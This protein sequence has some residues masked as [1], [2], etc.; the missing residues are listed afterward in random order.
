MS[1]INSILTIAKTDNKNIDLIEILTSN[2]DVA[3]FRVDNDGH[4]ALGINKFNT[5][6]SDIQANLHITPKDIHIPSVLVESGQNYFVINNDGNVGIG[7]SNPS[8]LLHV[9]GD[10][11]I[12]GDLIIAGK[13]QIIDT[14]IQTTEQ[15]EITNDGTGTTLIVNQNGTGP[16]AEF[17]YKSN[18]ALYVADGGFVGINTIN[19]TTHLEIDGVITANSGIMDIIESKASQD[20]TIKTNSLERVTIDHSTGYLGINTTT[21]TTHLD[22]NGTIT[23]HN[24]I[25]NHI[26]TITNTNFTV[27]TT[28]T[29]RLTIEAAGFVGINTTSPTTQLEVDGV[30]TANAGIMDIIESKTSQDFIIKTNNTARITVDNS[31]G[32]V[33]VNTTDPTTH[34]DVNGTITS[35]NAIMNHIGTITNTN[36]TVKTTNT[37]RL[38]IEADGF[39]GINTITPTTQLEVDGVITANSGIM[40]V[41]ESK[42][43]QDFT[44]KTNNAARITVDNSSGYVGVNTTDP[45]THFDVNGTITSHNA[46]MNHIGT[47][48]NTDFTIKTT[49]LPRVTIEADGYVGINTTAP[50]TQLEVDGVIT[51]N[52]GIMDI[53]ESKT[54][55][56]FTIKTDNTARITVDNA[57]GYVG[58]NTT[59]PTT[60][61]DVNGTLTSHNAIM[62]HIGTITNTDFTIKTTDLPRITVEADGFVGINTTAPTTQLE[63]DGVITANSGIMDIIESKTS[64]DFTIKTDNTAR[65]TVDNSSGYVGINTTD[66]TTHLDVNGTITSHNAIMDHIGTITNTNFTVKTTNTPRLTIEADG[67]VGINTTAPTTQLEVDGV[68][69]ANSGIMDVIESKTS[70]DFTIKTNNTARITVDNSSGY[71]GVNT[72]NPT[73]HL[74]VNGTLTSHNAIMNH[75]GTITNTDFTIKT[76]DLPRVTIEADGYVGIN[77]ITPTTQLEVDGVLTA[78]SGIMDMIESKTSQDFTIKTNNN[79]RITVDNADGYVGI[80]TTNPNTHLDVNGTITSH[81]AIMD[82][83]GTITNTDFTIKTTDLPR[84]TV[85]AD[86]YVGINTTNPATQLEVDGIITANGGIMDVIESKT[87]QDFTIKTNNT[88]RITVDNSSGYVGVNTINPTTTL[89][90]NGGI[91]YSNDLYKDIKTYNNLTL[92]GGNETRWLKVGEYTENAFS[93]FQVLIDT[94]LND[95][96]QFDI[97]HNYSGK[98]QIKVFTSY[99]SSNYRFS[100]IVIQNY[101]QLYNSKRTI[102]VSFSNN[103][104]VS[105]AQSSCKITTKELFN[106]F[107][108]SF[109]LTDIE[110]SR[111]I[112]DGNEFQLGEAQQLLLGFDLKC[113]SSI[114]TANVISNN[115]GSRSDSFSIK[116]SQQDRITILNSGYVGIATTNPLHQL[117]VE[118]N[119]HISG[120]L[121][122]SGSINLKDTNELT[123]EQLKIINDGPETA[124][125]VNQDGTGNIAE[126]NSNANSVVCVTKDIKVGINNNSPS[127]EL[128]VN[129]SIKAS[130]QILSN[131]LKTIDNTD[132]IL[133]TDNTTR[134]IINSAGNVGIGTSVDTDYK[135]FIDGDTRISGNLKINGTTTIIDTDAQT[136]EQLIIT[137]DGTG[138]AIVINQIGETRIAEFKDDNTTKIIID[139]SGNL[140]VKTEDTQGY[141]LYVQGK[142]FSTFIEG[143]EA[144]LTNTTMT[145]THMT[146]TNLTNTVLKDTTMI[147]TKMTDTNLTNTVLKDTTMTNT[148]M[149]D[150]NLTNTVL[151]DTTMTNT[152]MTDTNLTNTVL[153]DTTMT[154]THMTDTN[155][156]NT[157]LKD[158]T[159]TNTHMT[160]TNLTNTVLKD[161]TMINTHMTDTNLTNT[162]LKDTTMTNTHMTDTN[163][164]NTVLKDTTMTNTHMTDTN[165]T[166]TV[167]KDTTMTNTKM[168]DTNLT[169]TVLKDTTMTNTKMTDTNLTNTVLKDTTMINTHMT[170]TNL[171]NTVLKDTTMTNTKMT[172]TNL[173][174][175]VLKDTTMTNTKMTD[176][177]LT[178]TVLKDTTM[179]NTKMTDTNLTNTVLKDTTMTNT[180]MTD[181]N[182]T[183]TVLKDTTMTNTKMTDT[184]LTNTVLKDTTMTNTHMTDTNLTNTVL[185]DT[186]MTNTK[187]TDTNLTNTVL[188]DT[189][190]TNTHMT[191]TNLTNTV[192]K[193]TTMINTHMTD[194]N[195]TNTVLKDTTMTN[196]KMTDTNLTNTVLKDTTMTNTKMTDTNLTNTVLKDTTMTNTHMTD[197]NLINV[198]INSGTINDITIT[199]GKRIRN[200]Q[201]QCISPYRI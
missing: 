40:D 60:H 146:D 77:T 107:N 44:I 161:T 34:L 122:V 42:T 110:V 131:K 140:G 120:D 173:T 138:P 11:K 201:W 13:T 189:T 92:Q 194:T 118:G 102:W 130:E 184:N 52:S 124:L 115:I 132:F 12:E 179:T 151:K 89:D 35:H 139:S 185:K 171:T 187:M 26:G 6:D 62:D 79:A 28:N 58:I 198:K 24:A 45:T 46:I 100:K 152:H 93:T 22:V 66:P 121:T 142:L 23:S 176:T 17:N 19:P 37:P 104:N 74:D 196:T 125:V 158:T 63:V 105:T 64:Q 83:I 67:F 182:L 157:I 199:N 170:D 73:T 137:N 166:N 76:T 143:S 32:Y 25:M 165:L 21:P 145:N 94:N 153:K 5:S 101:N 178:N 51:A 192:L 72:T 169:N 156:T 186:T 71:V 117:H 86:G 106:R 29:P 82:H 33:G 80:N 41:I 135:F 49:D 85:D 160:D 56:D 127:V 172:D 95:Y 191:D 36:F 147:N 87:S 181:T 175:T 18:S 31:S 39:V 8:K 136:T 154:N 88:A 99:S 2:S 103:D 98:E 16:I 91:K 48:T 50:T 155:L 123:S 27:K 174:N 149:T 195:L 200:F 108:S 148:H 75:I 65:I 163:L 159:M 59:N 68:I 10:A 30:I 15:L 97:F 57:D 90:V 20:F 9:F 112:P 38:T 43:S 167:L 78:N 190:M 55:Q 114:E 69:T 129:G 193:D 4:V 61:L 7:S 177:N 3:A 116:T 141:D 47:I 1:H 168:T 14:N 111:N 133:Q 126:F 150:T 134:L 119:A 188:K 84:V 180:H 81:N 197:T 70:Q 164:T 109:K 54:S 113:L 96:I 144:I 128:D 162:V 53:I 183:N